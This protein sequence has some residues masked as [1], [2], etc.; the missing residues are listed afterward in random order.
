[1]PKTPETNT[2]PIDAAPLLFHVE[3]IQERLDEV[4]T[5]AGHNERLTMLGTMAASIAHEINNILTPVKAY[6]ELALGSPG[7]TGLVIKA[8]ERAAHGVDRATRI[9]EMILACSRPRPSS[10]IADVADVAGA[11]MATCPS[12]STF[13]VELELEPGLVAA[14]DAVALEQ[15]LVNLLLNAKAAMPAGGTVT[16]SGKALNATIE[17]RVTDTGNGIP[18]ERLSGV[19]ATFVSFPSGGQERGR[20]GLGLPI[21]RRLLAEA[22]GTIDLESEVGLGT[23][24]RIVIPATKAQH[25]ASA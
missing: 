9:S 5:L 2:A 25:R 18:P 12:T 1:M 19:F 4:A 15:V 21:C 10:A 13:H 7:D 16:I 20:T 22:G 6:A 3:R 17:I 14:I 8:L 23:T 24:A 11:A